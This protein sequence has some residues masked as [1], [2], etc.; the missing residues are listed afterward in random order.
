METN[1]LPIDY[2]Y[3]DFGGKNYIKIIGRNDKGKR[4]CVID[5]CDVYLWAILKEKLKNEKI[6]KLIEKIKKIKIVGKSRETTVE[7]VELHGKN[8]L[9]KEV[10]AL[11]IF[12]TNYKD[13]HDVADKL[14]FK[15][16]DKRRGYDLGYVTHYIMEKKILPSNW[17][18]ISGEVLNNSEEFGG[19]DSA[20]DV[21]ICI[22]LERH[23]EIE[24]KK[25]LPNFL[26]FD[27][28]TDDL[29]IGGGEI[30]MIS[31]VGKNFKKVITWKKSSGKKPSYVEY[32]KDEADL[33]EKF[34]EEVKKFSPDFLVGYFSDGFDLPYLKARAEKHKVKL[35]LGIDGSQPRFSRGLNI[36]G[37]ISGIVHI[38]LLKFIRT[39]YSQYMQSETLSLNEVASE[40]LNDRKKKFKFRHSS[41]IKGNE[42][43]EYYEYNLHDSILTLGLVEKFWPDIVEFSRVMQEPIFEVSRNGMSKNVE[44]YILHN[45][46]KFNEIP[47]KRPGHSEISG[48]RE[49]GKYEGAFVLEPTPGLYENVVIFDFTSSYGSVI[50]SYNL[51]KST[52]SE[53]KEG[54]SYEIELDGKKVY[55]SKKT[56]FFPEMLK[57]IIE[58]RKKYKKELNEKPDVFKKARSNAFKL[59]ANSSYGYQGFFGA[60]YYCREA[61]A[62]TAA[63]AKKAIKDAIEKINE[64][65][66]QTIYSDTDSIAFL[67][68]ENSENKVK[69]FLRELNSKL[70]GIMEL[71]LEGFFKRGIWVTKRSGKT[72]A[73]KKYALID[74]KGKIKIRGFETVRR[75][76]CKLSRETQNKVI[77]LILKNGN[78]KEALEYIKEVI[79]KLKNRKIKTEELIIRTQLKKPLSEYLSISPHV[80]AAQKM[81]EQ[82]IPIS[83]GGLV[84]YYIAETKGDGKLVRDKV[85]LPNEKGEYNIKYYLERQILPAVENLLQVFEINIKEVIEGKRQTTL[86]D[87]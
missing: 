1:F 76:W 27:I 9:G 29:K 35:S 51:S 46:E 64:K 83:E 82:Q 59:L 26:T 20:L 52:F 75:D 70:P 6:D 48:R 73:K 68:K 40:F 58:K 84:E 63:F 71:E 61:A 22:K 15:E 24:D 54:E 28:E 85:K 37:R 47:E 19:I 13:L 34:S 78:E 53:N 38:D 32:V 39:A 23:K 10:N 5:S 43:K 69:E 3:F 49:R 81:K 77:S 87:Y 31:L 62:A 41:I 33:I 45:L 30:L 7:K 12:A 66:Y 80:V 14:I 55:F 56:G 79:K 8:F 57:E 74:E 4:I 72:G 21:D 50:V 65:G 11:K 67:R 86:G 2:D 18:E 25:F 44:S 17:Y 42:W 16:I 60:R 36:T